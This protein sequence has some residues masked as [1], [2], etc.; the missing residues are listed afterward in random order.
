VTFRVPRVAPFLFISGFCALIYQVAWL[1]ELRLIFGASTGASAAV[2]AVFMAGLGFGGLYFGRRVDGWRNPLTGYANLELSIAV[3]AAITPALVW[4]ARKAYFGSGGATSLGSTGATALR[5][6]L[7]VLILGG[8]TFLMG[9][10]LPAAAKAVSREDDEGRGDVAVL[11]GL[12][13]LGAV[14]GT[15]LASFMLLEV[16]GTR[17]TLWMAC[18]VNAL[19]GLTARMVARDGEIAATPAKAA[20]AKAAPKKAAEGPAARGDEDADDDTEAPAKRKRTRAEIVEAARARAKRAK[21]SAAEAAEAAETPEGGEGGRGAPAAEVAAEEPKEAAANEA[22]DA[23]GAEA[24]ADGDRGA[25]GAPAS[26]PAASLP[27]VPLAAAFVSGFVF[28]LLELVWYRMLGPLLGG[29]S[30]TFGLILSIALVGIG[31]GSATYSLWLGKRPATIGRFGYTCAFEALAV[32]LPLVLGDRIAVLALL[33]RPLSAVGFW[34]SVGAWSVVTFVVVFPAAFVS[35]LQFP[36]LIGLFGRGSKSVGA[37]VGTA[38]V[39]NTVGAILGSLAGGFGFLPWL[40]A[41]GCWRLVGAT[42]LVTAGAAF[43]LSFRVEG[44]ARSLVVGVLVTVVGVLAV[45]AE[46][47]TTLWRTS[48][49]GAGRDDAV[50]QNADRNSLR[51]HENRRRASVVWDADGLE[52]HVAVVR[53]TG[54]AFL[55]NGKSDGD[56]RGDAATQVMGGLLGAALHP[57]PKRALVVGLGTGSTAGWLARV[58]SIDRV[59]VVELEPAILRVARDCAPVNEDVL[60]NPKVKVTLGDARE[61]LLSTRETYDVV[62]SEPSN[63]YRAGVSSM[64]TVEYYEAVRD[65]L[66]ANGVFVQWMQGYETDGRTVRAVLATLRTVFP[67][68]SVW[69]SMPGDLLIQASAAPVE[70]DA[71]KLRARLEVEPYKSAM[72]WTWRASGVEGLLAHFVADDAVARYALRTAADINR[73]DRNILEFAYART[74]GRGGSFGDV[75]VALA[76]RAMSATSPPVRGAFDAARVRQARVAMLHDNDVEPQPEAA[77]DRAYVAAAR[78][79]AMKNPAATMDAWKAVGRRPAGI[80]ELEMVAVS[81]SKLGDD[82]ALEQATELEKIDPVAADIARAY[83]AL[84]RRDE[85]AATARFALAF[86]RARTFPWVRPKLLM[87]ALPQAAEL[88]THHPPAR[89]VL[90][91]ALAQPFASGLVHSTR[92]N[93]RAQIAFELKEASRCAEVLREME[94]NVEWSKAFLARRLLCYRLA[95]DPAGARAEEDLAE[96]LGASAEPFA[97]EAELPKAGASAGVADAPVSAPTPTSTPSGS[98]SAPK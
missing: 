46:G 85:G 9:G 86:T 3:V 15:F 69:R 73:D 35:G 75:E 38:Y 2:L 7:A 13:T 27:P 14:I 98:A 57:D 59:D 30:Y 65:R 79:F 6:G 95:K 41:T 53:A 10:T 61:V 31:T 43:A 36:M 74:V 5:L 34:G 87:E 1:R 63:P 77:E 83:H 37:H 68:V 84:A 11:Y 22:T 48:P 19:V 97:P 55:V 72:S 52:S 33:L 56:S 42:L 54:L 91:D 8:P 60:T 94:P 44:R 47:P 93:V 21:A 80:F 12:N 66:R 29:S 78:A 4:A 81:A 51:A 45:R 23:K 64:Y 24:T 58:P 16:F 70:I 28:F 26:P 76:A 92:M 71:E 40:S 50:L 67:Y 89:A 49:I 96:L 88:A 82:R 39:A 32:L 25:K 90:L 20:P 17:L 18:L 62:F